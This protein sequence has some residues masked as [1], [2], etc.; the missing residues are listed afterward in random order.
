[1]WDEKFLTK[2]ERIQNGNIQQ[3]ILFGLIFL[4]LA[5][6]GMIYFGG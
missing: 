2:F 3:Y 5:I 6:I 4:I 1:M